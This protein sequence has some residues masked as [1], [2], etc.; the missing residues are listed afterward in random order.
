[1]QAVAEIEE[2]EAEIEGATEEITEVVEIEAAEAE[3]IEAK[4]N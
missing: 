4:R 3:G 1:M 2:K